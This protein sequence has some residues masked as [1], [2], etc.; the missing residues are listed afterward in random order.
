MVLYLIPF[1]YSMDIIQY[2]AVVNCYVVLSSS[3]M[4]ALTA[5]DYNVCSTMYALAAQDYNVC[6]TMYALA[7]Q[8][9]NVCSTM[10]ALAA[11]DYNV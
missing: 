9:Y 2:D 7:A 4:Y 10:Y 8:N 11:Q 5:Q 1:Y 3:T 6:S